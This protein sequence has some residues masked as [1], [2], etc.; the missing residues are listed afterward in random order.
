MSAVNH[1]GATVP[2]EEFELNLDAHGVEVVEE[3]PAAVS[4]DL[5]RDTNGAFALEIESDQDE[6]RWRVELQPDQ[7]TGDLTPVCAYANGC[8]IAHAEDSTQP[9]IAELAQWLRFVIRY[10]SSEVQP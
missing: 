7:R 6:Q 3:A 9:D 10:I 2:S 5:V 1:G 8:V 4:A